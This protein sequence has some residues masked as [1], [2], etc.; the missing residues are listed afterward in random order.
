MKETKNVPQLRFSGFDDEWE[1][2]KF[3]ELYRKSS[4]KND[5]TLGIEKNITVATMQF[6]DDILVSTDE[7]L[8]TYYT[9]NLG[10]IAFEGHQSKEFRFGRFVENDIGNGIVSHIFAVF[11][12]IVNYD[13]MFWKYA[14]NNEILMQRVLSRST[15]ASTMMH[16]LV[17]N[18]F[19]EQNFLVPTIAEQ[20]KI[21]AFLSHVDSLIQAKTK[22]LESLKAVKKSL[23]Q[24]C[25]PKAGEKV[26]E[27][28]FAGFKGEW[29]EK[30]LG[31]VCQLT[32][33]QSPDGS[34]YS[35]TPSTYILVQGNA[36]MK[37]GFVF[38]RIWTTQKTKIAHPGDLIFSVRAPVGEVGKT[39]Y[40]IVIGRGVAALKG[41]EFV[42]QELIKMNEFGYW[43]TISCGSTFESINSN[44]LYNAEISIP[45]TVEEQQKIGQFF[46]KYDSLISAL[47]KEINKL[48]DIKKSLLQ[49]MFI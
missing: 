19:L 14:I 43:N 36:D 22:K 33:G 3:G 20:Q 21:G 30:K 44:D 10:D 46:S 9:F 26:P 13:L 42:F 2:C 16:D 49:K 4:E 28:R 47:Q 29:E 23:L 45:P 6:K 27:M 12:P 48:K 1:G 34:T 25:F 35:V 11:R 17:T 41:N 31:E 15:K 7:Y 40:E 39:K 18:D 32:M 37:D 24:K 8:K 5:G 38:P